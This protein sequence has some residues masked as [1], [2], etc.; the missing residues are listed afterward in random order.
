LFSYGGFGSTVSNGKAHSQWGNC[1]LPIEISITAVSEIMVNPQ[2]VFLS[3]T[4][5]E[6]H[7]G[8]SRFN[9]FHSRASTLAATTSSVSFQWV[10]SIKKFCS[11]ER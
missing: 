10:A 3:K 5:F 9:F 4:P 7:L 8:G 1:F 11:V 2:L 6:A